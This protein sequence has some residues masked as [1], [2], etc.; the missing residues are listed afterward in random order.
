MALTPVYGEVDD[1]RVAGHPAPQRRPRCHLHRHRQRLRRRRQR[2]AHR[3][4]ARR[5]SRRGDAGDQVRHHRQPGRG[6]CRRQVERARRRRLRPAVHRREPGPA[7]DRRRRPLLHAPPRPDGADRGDRRSDGRTGRRRQ[8]PSS[9]AVRGDRRRAARRC[10]G[11]PHRRR[12]ERVVDLEPRRRRATW[13]P[14]PSNSASASCRT[15]PWAADSSPAPCGRPPI[16]RLGSDFRRG[17]PRFAGEAL[18]ANLA[19]VDMIRGVAEAA[20]GHPGTGRAGVAAVPRRR[21]RGGVGADPRHATRGAGRGEPRLA[22]RGAEPTTSSRRSTTP[23]TRCRAIGSAISAGCR[24]AANSRSI[25]TDWRPPRR[26]TCGHDRRDP[27]R[28]GQSRWSTPTGQG[29][30]P[31]CAR[32]IRRLPRRLRSRRADARRRGRVGAANLTALLLDAPA[33]RSHHRPRP[34]SS[35]PGGSPRSPAPRCI[36]DRTAR[37]GRRRRG[38]ARRARARHRLPDRPS[39][40]HHRTARGG[41]ARSTPTDRCGTP[42]ECR[43]VV[44]APTDHRPVEPTIGFRVEYA[45]RRWCWPAT[46]SRATSLDALAAGAERWCTP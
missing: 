40:R 19:V 7:E 22:G 38:H 34:T 18:E 24:Q 3:P 15:R 26:Y 44:A 8:G 31:W 46:P 42:T 43:I 6:P 45:R 36:G 4:I 28:H 25:A 20:G 16:W 21:A 29:P 2:A 12:A 39:R 35:P 10:C 9:R 37:H 33:Q 5:P 27:A 30:R 41:G 1:D 14:P 13:C 11:P 23:A 32:A 17:L